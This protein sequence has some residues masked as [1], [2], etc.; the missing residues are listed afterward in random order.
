MISIL[1]RRNSGTTLISIVLRLSDQ[2][3]FQPSIEFATLV[4]SI[5]GVIQAQFLSLQDNF[6]QRNCQTSIEFDTLV[7]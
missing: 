5:S 6:D 4:I 3:N 1:H 7:L 2:R